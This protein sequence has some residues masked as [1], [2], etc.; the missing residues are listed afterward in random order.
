MN[1]R[2][3][4]KVA[5][6]LA[7]R[8]GPERI[9][10][11]TAHHLQIK[12]GDSF[13]DV[14]APNEGPL[15]F[16]RAGCRKVEV[17]KLEKLADRLGDGGESD[18]EQ[19]RHAVELTEL[20]A[21]A[22]RSKLWPAV[23]VDAGWKDGIGQIAAVA[24]RNGQHGPSVA[25]Q[26]YCRPCESS[27][28]AEGKAASLGLSMGWDGCVVYTDCAATAESAEFKARGVKR[29]PRKDNLADRIAN[30]RKNSQ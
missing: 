21:R 29:L 3:L 8:F 19:A 23:F 5:K 1:P 25:A 4:D 2:R 12:S 9:V 24:I 7:E 11:R 27:T 22:K 26:S 15:K 6:A 28:I 18:L 14:W 13:H 10:V 17:S 16:R 20:I 30:R